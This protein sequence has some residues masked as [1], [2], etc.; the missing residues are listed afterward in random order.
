MNI[1]RPIK[2]W[3]V[4][5][6]KDH[7]EIGKRLNIVQANHGKSA[8]MKRMVPGDLILFY[9]PKIHFEGKDP[10]KKFTAIARVKDGEVY[11]GDMGGGFIAYR[12][13]VDYLPCKEADIVPLIPKMTFIRNKKSWGFVFKFGFFEIPR[14]DFEMIAK[15][16]ELK[17]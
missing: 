16:M 15:E 2:F 12:R 14:E 8:P 4:V 13:N 11:S 7:M 17:D 5:V 10:L 6:S 1:E 3:I 9:S